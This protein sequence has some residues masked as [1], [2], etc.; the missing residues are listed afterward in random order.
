MPLKVK[1]DP[2]ISDEDLDAIAVPWFAF[3]YCTGPPWYMFQEPV[4]A[5]MC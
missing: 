3:N 2:D 4:V 5:R 1:P